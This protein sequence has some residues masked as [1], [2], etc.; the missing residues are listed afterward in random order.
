MNRRKT[1]EISS[2]KLRKYAKN[3]PTRLWKGLNL[4]T[5]SNKLMPKNFP[6]KTGHLTQRNIEKLPLIP[7][8]AWKRKVNDF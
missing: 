4:E 6:K 8:A 5:C 7:S 1:I 2:D 3:G